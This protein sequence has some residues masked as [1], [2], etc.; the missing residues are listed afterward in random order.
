MIT[1]YVTLIISDLRRSVLVRAA[2][3][4]TLGSD[5]V[6]F[7]RAGRWVAKFPTDGILSITAA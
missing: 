4:E 3:Y 6:F 5:H 7:D 2:R 1:Y